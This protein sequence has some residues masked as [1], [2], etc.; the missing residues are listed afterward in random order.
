[1]KAGTQGVRSANRREFWPLVVLV[2]ALCGCA[3]RAAQAD[4]MT[5]GDKQRFLKLSLT[6]SDSEP[7]P[8]SQIGEHKA[9]VFVFLDGNCPIC[10]R[11]AAILNQLQ[12]DYRS[13][14]VLLAGVFPEPDVDRTTAAVFQSEYEIE[15]P[16]LADPERE[17]T[18]LLNATITPEA[19]VV[20]ARG[21][22]RYRG[23]I[24]NWF[25]GPGEK[26]AVVT[27][28][29]LQDA[30]DNLIAGREIDPPMTKPVGCYIF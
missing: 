15:F 17:L 28:H 9:T 19:V 25:L 4:P 8:L 11:Y 13:R 2:G 18:A 30:L 3:D 21:E 16:L 26:R 7:F 6:S 22:I 5:I 23:A 1:M 24:S 29:Y 12:L 20:D 27:E 10:Q 14:G